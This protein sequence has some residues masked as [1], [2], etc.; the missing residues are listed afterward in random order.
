MNMARIG[1]S[2][3]FTYALGVCS[4][5]LGLLGLAVCW[6]VP[7]GMVLSLTGMMIGLAGCVTGRRAAWP[8]PAAGLILS[9]ASLAVCWIVAA[10]GM[11]LIRLHALR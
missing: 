1:A 3:R 7:T 11:E 8:L 5:V 6:W 9:A 10:E 4:L 2:T